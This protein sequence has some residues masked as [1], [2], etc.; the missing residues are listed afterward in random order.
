MADWKAARLLAQS[1]FSSHI[2]N[3]DGQTVVEYSGVFGPSL[4]GSATEMKGHRGSVAKQPE[5][6]LGEEMLRAVVVCSKG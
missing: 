6:R 2:S 5:L 4:A 1:S 3:A